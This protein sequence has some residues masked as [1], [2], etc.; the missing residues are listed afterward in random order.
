M[1]SNIYPWGVFVK[2]KFPPWAKKCP[3]SGKSLDNL[4]NYGMMESETNKKFDYLKI[5]VW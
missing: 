2:R 3:E 1:K 5:F 4:G